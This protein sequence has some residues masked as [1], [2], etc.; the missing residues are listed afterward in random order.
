MVPEGHR[1]E[2]ARKIAFLLQIRGFQNPTLVTL[3]GMAAFHKY[4]DIQPLQCFI[5]QSTWK[6]F[7]VY[8]TL[9]GRPRPCLD[10]WVCASL[11]NGKFPP[12]KTRDYMLSKAM[13]KIIKQYESDFLSEIGIILPEIE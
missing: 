13:I 7:R 6:A 4:L 10:E 5:N 12:L 8:S 3:E 1:W 9:K 11:K 2:E